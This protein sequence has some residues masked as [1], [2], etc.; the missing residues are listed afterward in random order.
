MTLE[1]CD[2]CEDLAMSL[3]SPRERRH[4]IQALKVL[5][6]EVNYIIIMNE[7]FMI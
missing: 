6:T 2:E 5:T 3:S 4:S 1:D 7:T